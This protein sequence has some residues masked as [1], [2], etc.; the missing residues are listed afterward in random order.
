MTTIYLDAS[1][2]VKLAVREAETDAL[3]AHVRGATMLFTSE[4]GAVEL[5]RAL[6]RAGRR[7]AAAL[8]RTIIDA[9]YLADLTPE[10]R[11][12]AGRL[13]PV[14]LRT[15]DAIHVATAASLELDDLEF[16]TYDD[17]QATAARAHGLIVIRPGL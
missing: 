16:I 9:V 4:V 17:R 14:A 2:L 13:A 15:L 11:A 8:V 10:I 6:N 12:L 1:A 5:H 7:D 3:S